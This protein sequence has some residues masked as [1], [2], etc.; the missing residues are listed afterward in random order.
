MGIDLKFQRRTEYLYVCVAG[1]F[2][3]NEAL[4]GLDITLETVARYHVTK[5][6]IDG[7]V[8]KGLLGNAE[9]HRYRESLTKELDPYLASGRI[10]RLRIALILKEPLIDH[11]HFWE[12]IVIRQGAEV[13]LFN[14]SA[15][16]L[17]WLIL[18]STNRSENI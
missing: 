6:L 8:L 16:A 5:V 14:N 2:S 17:Q 15:D 10:I 9:Y 18:G 13:C 4:D 1:D 11:S 7:L 12:S 3:L